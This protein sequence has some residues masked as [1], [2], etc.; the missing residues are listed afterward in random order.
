MGE[1]FPGRVACEKVVLSPEGFRVC[2]DTGEVI[3]EDV[4]S[5]DLETFYKWDHKSTPRVGDPITFTQHDLGV[6][7][8][9]KPKKSENPL[10]RAASTRRNIIK[11]ARVS[12]RDIH[13]V[14]IL[15][16]ANNVASKLGLPDVARE[17][18]GLIIQSYLSKE[19]VTGNKDMRSLVAAAL[20][21][22]I[23]KHNIGIAQSE[24][25]DILDVEPESVWNAKIKLHEKGVLDMYNRRIYDAQ[26]GVKRLLGR[27][28]TYVMRLV[29]ELNL[30]NEVRRDAM[31]FI[32]STL[33]SG[34]NL[35]GKRPETI[36]AAAVYLVAR[37]H[38]YENVNQNVIAEKLK[39]KESNVRKLYRYLMDGMVVLVVF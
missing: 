37:L 30:D 9:L 13:K 34:K 5:D 3:A 26:D 33:K 1:E 17:D 27:V 16:L 18:M 11:E 21:K 2:Y 35:Y 39:I 14:S 6:G 4:F 36:A 8:S 32:R 19:R 22:V 38:G 7:V 25:L 20:L 12:R 28:E 15:Q 10:K 31:E 29:S 24:V 23:E